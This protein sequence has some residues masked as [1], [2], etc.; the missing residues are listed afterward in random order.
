MKNAKSE[1]KDDLIAWTAATEFNTMGIDDSNRKVDAPCFYADEN[2]NDDE[3]TRCVDMSGDSTST[4]MN[5]IHLLDK[6]PP[7]SFPLP[8][9]NYTP[10][11]S[12]TI[13]P[14]TS[15]TCSPSF[16]RLPAELRSQ[17][18]GHYLANQVLP[19]ERHHPAHPG[20]K[21]QNPTSE[22]EI[23]LPDEL[24]RQFGTGRTHECDH[25][26]FFTCRALR[27][28]YM[29]EINN[30]V[31]ADHLLHVIHIG[32]RMALQGSIAETLAREYKHLSRLRKIKIHLSFYDGEERGAVVSPKGTCWTAVSCSSRDPL[33]LYRRL[34]NVKEFLDSLVVIE[35]VTVRLWDAEYDVFEMGEYGDGGE[36]HGD[37]E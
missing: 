7:T 22:K 36:V 24:R 1:N 16:L 17:I 9:Q 28:D 11:K 34:K 19:I 15:T 13:N 32:P 20:S 31:N 8:T 25:A 26:F 14:T 18:A 10:C 30:P 27:A 37:W 2:A 33:L 35:E 21:I 29:H 12:P 5:T 3:V 4:H 6:E 23:L